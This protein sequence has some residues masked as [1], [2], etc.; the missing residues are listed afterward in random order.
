M[1]RG[2]NERSP[3]YIPHPKSYEEVG[4]A[5]R[6]AF[7]LSTLGALLYVLEGVVVALLGTAVVTDSLG[8]TGLSGWA[9]VLW[10]VAT[11]AIGLILFLFAGMLVVAPGNHRLDGTM[12]LV[13]VIIGALFGFGT[14]FILGALLAFIGGIAAILWRPSRSGG[15]AAIQDAR[16]AGGGIR[17]PGS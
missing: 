6:A 5:P 15:T 3:S 2:V 11:F 7:F 13:L 10:G 12:I 16:S 8:G 1:R 14:G 4:G 9:V 17:Q